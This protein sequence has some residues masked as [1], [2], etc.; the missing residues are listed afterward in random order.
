VR[1][2]RNQRQD[3][4]EE[5]MLGRNVVCPGE[6]V[7]LRGGYW[8]GLYR[9]KG[10][11]ITWRVGGLSTGRGY[12]G[13]NPFN[14]GGTQIGPRRDPNT[15]DINRE[16]GGDKMCYIYGKWGHIVKTLDLIVEYAF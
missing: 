5:K 9:G 15:I 13:G 11:Q 4:A 10:K 12:K 14:R 1:L 7:Q 6:N 16:R 3:R 8:G 2:D